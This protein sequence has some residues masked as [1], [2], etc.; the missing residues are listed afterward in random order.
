MIWWVHIQLLHFL[1]SVST[2]LLSY[3]R[4]Q[5]S[6]FLQFR[7]VV[8]RWSLLKVNHF[9]GAQYLLKWLQA[10][11]LKRPHWEQTVRGPSGEWIRRVWV[12]CVGNWSEGKQVIFFSG[13]AVVLHRVL[14]Q[15]FYISAL[16][17]VN[18]I[19]S[20]LCSL[21]KVAF[22]SRSVLKQQLHL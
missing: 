9:K 15:A 13:V 4:R 18:S 11:L 16:T 22:P 12:E 17:G 7:D 8:E 14:Q 1:L 6:H 20:H 19:N 10:V 21:P 3:G 2:P 5:R